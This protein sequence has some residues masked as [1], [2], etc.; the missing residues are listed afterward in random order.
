M[1]LPSL[2]SIYRDSLPINLSEALDFLKTEERVDKKRKHPNTVVA[3]VVSRDLLE[4]ARKRGIK[5]TVRLVEAAMMAATLDETDHGRGRYA[6]AA[7]VL[8]VH[9]NTF[10]SRLEVLGPE[11]QKMSR[12]IRNLRRAVKAF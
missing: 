11:V 12:K 3:E 2:L 1:T 7:R 6:E 10:R 4:V 5:D 8:Q 9:I